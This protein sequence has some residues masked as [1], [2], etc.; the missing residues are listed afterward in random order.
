[1][2]YVRGESLRER[3]RREGILPIEE[4]LRITRQAAQALSYA[5]KEGVIHRDVKPENLLLTEDGSTQVADFGIARPVG[6]PARPA[7]HR[8]R[9]G[10][11]H[12]GLHGAGAVVG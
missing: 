4:A 2:P 7:A 12:T 10:A 5:H 1:M 8:D 11:R 9:R 6:P 3:L